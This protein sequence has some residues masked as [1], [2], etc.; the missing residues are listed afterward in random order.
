MRWSK[1]PEACHSR[2]IQRGREPLVV[3]ALKRLYG[4]LLARTLD[5]PWGMLTACLI[6]LAGTVATV[7]RLGQA[8]LPE[9]N[10]GALTISAVTLPGTSL[11]ESD[12]LGRAVERTIM[13]HPE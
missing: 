2:A 1:N 11:A 9:F 7:P 8:F 13:S 5:H 12:E 4:P 3:R 6:L 10:E